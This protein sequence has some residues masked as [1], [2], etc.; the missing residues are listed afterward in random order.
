MENNYSV[1]EILNAIDELEK[2]KKEKKIIPDK[3]STKIDSS[4]IPKDTLKLIEE[5]EKYKN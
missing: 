2:I 5:A 4:S 3:K 1:K